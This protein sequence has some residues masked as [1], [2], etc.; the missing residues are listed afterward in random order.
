M[1]FEVLFM[2]VPSLGRSLDFFV[3]R[4]YYQHK[5]TRKSFVNTGVV[6]EPRVDLHLLYF[7]PNTIISDHIHRTILI[8]SHTLELP[9]LRL[10]IDSS[11]APTPTNNL[12]LLFLSVES[13]L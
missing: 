7:C 9:L 1:D 6:H 8:E 12:L 3:V 10:D 2:T 5:G 11:T 4:F 13:L